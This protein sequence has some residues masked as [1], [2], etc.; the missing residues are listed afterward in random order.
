MTLL[1]QKRDAAA[2]ASAPAK[3]ESLFAQRRALTPRGAYVEMSF[4]GRVW[5]ELP[6]DM[7][8]AEIES[9]VFSQMEALKLPAIPI[10]GPSYDNRRLALTLAW[11]VRHPD[12]KEPAGTQAQW[13]DLDL[14]MLA[15][16]GMVYN[17]AREILSPLTSDSLTPAQVDA[18]QLA[19]KKKDKTLLL[20]C[21][22]VVL[23]NWL[24]TGASQPANSPTTASSTGPS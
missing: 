15:A 5:V 6:G 9:A 21:G 3:P 8:T 18:I 22:V 14:D 7:I 16:C 11:A 1:V 12:T 4:L 24:L 17:D 19:L 10:N 13:C 20:S 23:S 2:A